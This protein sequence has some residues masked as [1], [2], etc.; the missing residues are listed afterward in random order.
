MRESFRLQLN[1]ELDSERTCPGGDRT[2]SLLKTLMFLAAHR[3]GPL[4]TGDP[5]CVMVHKC[6][7]C[8]HDDAPIEIWYGTDTE[9]PRCSSTIYPADCLRLWEAVS[10]YGGNVEPLTRAMNYIE[11]LSIVQH[12]RYLVQRSPEALSGLC[13][14][15]D[16]PLACF[17]NAAW[18]HSQIMGVIYD[19]QRILQQRGLRP[20]LVIGLQKTG[21]VVEHAM[22]LDRVLPA[23]RYMAV[24]DDYRGTF[25]AQRPEGWEDTFGHETYYGQDFIFKTDTGRIFVFG[26]PYTM[27]SKEP[28]SEFRD[29]KSNPSLYPTLDTALHLV[30]HFELDLYQNAVI[31]I[32]LAHRHASISLVP[33][34]R[35]LDLLTAAALQTRS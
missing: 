12:V 28:I 9:C 7:T 20:F 26:L 35:V 21:Q 13:F 19:A 2:H 5:D 29:A 24:S 14:F 23:S 11:H 15:V 3:A 25:I 16:G 18:M 31:P 32:A 30:R 6:P 4:H 1:D 8:G 22:S 34:G 17:G 10:E 27:R 33:G